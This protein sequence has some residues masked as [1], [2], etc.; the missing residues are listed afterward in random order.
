MSTTT[1][2]VAVGSTAEIPFPYV[3]GRTMNLKTPCGKDVQ[4]TITRVCS[5]TVSPVMEVQ[6]RM[7]NGFRTAILKLFD[8]RF[9]EF[10]KQHPYNQQAEAAWQDCVRSG[11]AKRLLENLRL[12]EY[13][14]RNARFQ[15]D[16]D[17]TNE[18]ED[19][20]ED[21]AE[22]DDVDNVDDL[23]EWEAIIYHTAQKHYTNEVRAYGELKQLQGRC[24]P[25]FIESVIYSS[26]A[27]P[28]DLPVDY[29]QVPGILLECIHGFPLSELTTNIP[30]QPF[31]W[32][33]V[34]EGAIDVVREVNMMGVV[35][36]DCQPRNMLV[37]EMGH[38]AFQSYLIDFA[39]CAFR[40]DYKNTDNV[41]DEGGFAHIV[42]QADNHGGIAVLINQRVKKETSYTL[43][44][45]T[46]QEE[47]AQV[48]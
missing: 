47:Y 30:N 33:K 24:I 18:Q 42:H 13:R 9:G 26:S 20:D 14:V 41:D 1:T 46:L 45:K 29:F 7:P 40:A 12:D 28:A 23:G 5:V 36:Y 37:A 48:A 32:E 38:G 4:L 35:H 15:E 19:G 25:G 22:V 3:A 21:E 2:F 44:L 16:V 6:L 39:Q 17:D 8:R 31:L 11:L 43:H 27:A 10:R 34:V